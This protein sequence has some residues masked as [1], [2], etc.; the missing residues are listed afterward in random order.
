MHEVAQGIGLR[1]AQGVAGIARQ[2]DG[3]GERTAG[4]TD[5]DLEDAVGRDR[6]GL[7]RMGRALIGHQQHRVAAEHRAIGREV[8]QAGAGV[9]TQAHQQHG[10]RHQQL[11]RL[12]KQRDQHE[13]G[14]PAGDRAHRAPH[15]FGQRTADRRLRQQIDRQRR[16]LRVAQLEPIGDR[17]RQE[18][19]GRCLQREDDILP[20]DIDRKRDAPK[21][22]CRLYDAHR[23]ASRR[24]GF[25]AHSVRGNAQITRAAPRRPVARGGGI[26]LGRP[27]DNKFLCLSEPGRRRYELSMSKAHQNAAPRGKITSSGTGVG[28]VSLADI[29]AAAA[30]IQGEVLVTECNRSRTLSEICGCNIWLKFENLQFTSA[31]KERGALNRLHALTR[32]GAAARRD[33]DVGRQSRAG[34]G[35]SRHAARAFPPPSSCRSARRW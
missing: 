27:A 21:I 16:P 15:A 10:G 22:A 8:A 34:R 1:R 32:R 29:T 20:A 26:C 4:V 17:Q 12:R 28:P 23:S 31:F 18:R 11:G 13:P 35:L 9:E 7:Q 30:T 19:G 24:S 5:Q 2:D 25:P 3:A 6:P 14:Q 33:R